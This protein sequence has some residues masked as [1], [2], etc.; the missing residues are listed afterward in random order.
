MNKPSS[1]FF[2]LGFQ[3]HEPESS[4]NSTDFPLIVSGVRPLPR[5]MVL[6]LSALHIG[7]KNLQ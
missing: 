3:F 7:G 1:V 6:S 4:L 2:T 5:Y